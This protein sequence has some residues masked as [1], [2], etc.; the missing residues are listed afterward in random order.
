VDHGKLSNTTQHALVNHQNVINQI[1]K[2]LPISEIIYELATFDIH[3]LV[4]A[5]VSGE[6]YQQGEL[7]GF[8]NVREYVLTRDKYTCQM[9]GKKKDEVLHV[10]HIEH[11]SKGGS[12]HQ[13]NLVTLHG[14]CHDKVHASPKVEAKLLALLAKKDIAKTVTAPATIMNTIMPRLSPWR[15][16]SHPDIAVCVTFGYITKENRFKYGI[17]KSHNNDAF[18]IACGNSDPTAIKRYKPAT[19]K[20]FSRNS[21]L[22]IFGTKARKYTYRLPDGGQVVCFNR[23]RATAQDGKKLSLAE[24]RKEYGKKAVSELKVVKGTRMW[25]DTSGY[26]FNKGDTVWYQGREETVLGNSNGGAYVRLVS[27]PK[28][29]VKPKQCRLIQRSTGFVKVA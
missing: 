12:D 14:T 6:G 7:M 22:W 15:N 25:I 24:F 4:N 23:Q 1:T 13:T 16:E 17:G 19:Y 28:K 2:I 11:R 10:H 26:Q 8:A 18:V 5:E 20:Q 21:R 9:C 29:N 27:E 3:K